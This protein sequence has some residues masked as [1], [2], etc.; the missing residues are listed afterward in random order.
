M[1]QNVCSLYVYS[2][3][4]L[5]K[6]ILLMKSAQ[7]M[8]PEPRICSHQLCSP[9]RIQITLNISYWR[10]DQSNVDVNLL[11][12]VQ[13]SLIRF[14]Y[15]ESR[16]CGL[17]F[18]SYISIG[19]VGNGQNRAIGLTVRTLREESQVRLRINLH[20]LLPTLIRFQL[21]YHLDV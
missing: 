8:Q 19:H 5:N 17:D 18:I 1:S 12:L 4:R 3:I 20:Y 14:D 9:V 16:S 10:G 7:W 15:V 13:D 11:S 21:S 2:L 6:V